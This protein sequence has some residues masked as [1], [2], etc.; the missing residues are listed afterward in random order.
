VN[1]ALA[2][3]KSASGVGFDERFPPDCASVG[4][5]RAGDRRIIEAEAKRMVVIHLGK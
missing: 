5:D 2:P 1:T 3:K 4:V